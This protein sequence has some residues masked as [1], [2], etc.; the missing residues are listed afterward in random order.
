VSAPFVAQLRSAGAPIMLG[1][2]G[3]ATITIRVESAEL[4]DAV[5][6]IAPPE[7]V[8]AEVKQRAVVGFYPD[9]E[10]AENFVLKFRGWE[11]LDENASLKDCGI[12]NGSILLL[13]YRR[14]RPVR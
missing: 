4:W 6:V 5:R 1:E 3:A 2:P 13:G 11:I 12:V 9:N 14:R 7:T 10:Y 8:L